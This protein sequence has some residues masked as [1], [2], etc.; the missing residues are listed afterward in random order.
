V[1][2]LAIETSSPLGSIAVGR[3]GEL[4]AERTHEGGD[5]HAE[6]LFPLL[7][8]LLA[9]A[10][11]KRQE[12]QSIAVGVGPGSFTGLRVGIAFAEGIATGL[13]LPLVGIPSLAGL[14]WS[15][16]FPAGVELVAAVLDA[17]RDELFFAVFDRQQRQCIEPELIASATAREHIERRCNGKTFAIAGKGLPAD[18]PSQWFVPGA[19]YPT[20]AA[21]LK[22]SMGPLAHSP[23]TA[24]YLRAPDLKLP[25]L[26]PNPLLSGP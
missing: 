7:D 1:L 26:V 18:V 25:N 14:A 12:L 20:A 5:A 24:L 9:E 11:V 16:P 2:T 6:A 23:A 19:Q 21:A 13:G 15:H 22:L 10:G 3:D 17:R 4:L 8:E